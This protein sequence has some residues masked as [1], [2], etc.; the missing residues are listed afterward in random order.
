MTHY[1]IRDRRRHMNTSFDL[2]LAVPASRALAAET[3]LGEAHARIAALERELSEF[4]PESP[5][6]RVNAAP[7]R[8]EIPLPP[9]ALFL[10]EE[11][12]RL[13]EATRGA[14][15]PTAKSQGPSLPPPEA[16]VGWDRA[17]GVAWR[18]HPG[19]ALGFG[20][21]GK[22]YALDEVR[23]IL[24]REG[25]T[26]YL[27]SAGGSSLLFSGF[28]AP[29]EP[30]S[31]GWSWG[32]S[33]DGSPLGIP[34]RHASGAPIAVGV[35][36]LEEQPRHLLDPRAG[37][38]PTARMTSALVAHPS[39][40]QADALSTALFVAGWEESLAA[41]GELPDPP[42]MAIIDREG[43]PAWNGLFSRLWGALAVLL[44]VVASAP[45]GADEAVDLGA[46]GLGDPSLYQVE[47]NPWWLLLPALSLLLV[48]AHLKKPNKVRLA[49]RESAAC[50]Q[51]E[52]T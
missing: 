19:A 52:R 22:G 30:W 41:L 32:A 28:S 15:D 11:S 31:W 48:L 4:L 20:A 40:A 8:V 16:R 51:K 18:N 14:F 29:D 2:C 25:F 5:I 44:A 17:R 42:A 26:D 1:H 6:A 33:D 7:P 38:V 50:P 46:L 49:A 9:S 47:R 3:T 34:L 36:G 39:A 43:V 35:S 10:L 24:E 23:S 13:R 21:I 45:A 12:A 27:L 37:G